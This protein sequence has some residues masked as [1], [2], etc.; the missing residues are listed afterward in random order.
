MVRSIDK[1]CDW[2][3]DCLI[4]YIVIWL[5]E[6]FLTHDLLNSFD[7][8]RNSSVS[9]HMRVYVMR[10]MRVTLYNRLIICS[11]VVVVVVVVVVIQVSCV[12]SI[13]FAVLTCASPIAG[14]AVRK[15]GSRPTVIVGGL[16]AATGE[17]CCW[18]CGRC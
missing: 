18:W 4:N 9:A 6:N 2:L 3:N 14:A 17:C 15:F 10:L 16:L 12:Q 5:N 7:E 11:D 1:L 8:Q 13:S